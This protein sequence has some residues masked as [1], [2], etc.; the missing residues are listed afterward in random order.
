M[1]E[2]RGETSMGSVLL[3][4]ECGSSQPQA[5][6]WSGLCMRVCGA[7]RCL[8]PPCRGSSV[9]GNAPVCVIRH[10][11]DLK[12]QYQFFTG[13]E[14]QLLPLA[15]CLTECSIP[16]YLVVLECIWTRRQNSSVA[17]QSSGENCWSED[18]AV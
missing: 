8:F 7:E 11:P 15:S 4:V 12:V 16:V 18:L 1:V 14:S 6:N 9:C 17:S 2:E 3:V 5:P 13:F 10:R